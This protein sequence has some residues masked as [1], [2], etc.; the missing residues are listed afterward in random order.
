MMKPRYFLLTSIVALYVA[1]VP[2]MT[3]IAEPVTKSKSS[4][5]AGKTTIKGS[6]ARNP[7]LGAI[8][9]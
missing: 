8:V 1:V 2:A 4:T 5:S 6:M 3:S 7:Y 9:V